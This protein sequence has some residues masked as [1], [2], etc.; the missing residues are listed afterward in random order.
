MTHDFARFGL[1][2]LMVAAPP[3]G[4]W[5][6]RPHLPHLLLLEFVDGVPQIAQPEVRM[7]TT[8]ASARR[9]E[10]LANLFLPD[11]HL[12]PVG[13]APA[14]NGRTGRRS[15]S[16]TERDL[17][18]RSVWSCAAPIPAILTFWKGSKS[19]SAIRPMLLDHDELENQEVRP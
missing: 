1:I 18:R 19:K 16:L 2:A 3:S 15:L 13:P 5:G 11:H 12:R 6:R 4:P 9:Y 17:S 8:K 7:L 10:Q 14:R